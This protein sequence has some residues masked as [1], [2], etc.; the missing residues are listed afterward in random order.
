MCLHV[1]FFLYI[2]FFIIWILFWLIKFYQTNQ[3]MPL[4]VLKFQT[5][6]CLSGMYT[7]DVL[8]YDNSNSSWYKVT[9]TSSQI[10]G[11][12]F[13]DLS[14]KTNTICFIFFMSDPKLHS[15]KYM[16]PSHPTRPGILYSLQH[17]S[18]L[19]TYTTPWHLT[20]PGIL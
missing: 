4:K 7:V 9:L 14:S 13:L 16:T 6:S 5:W 10:L 18:S 12:M 8:S 2:D 1:F 17:L 15:L 20:R 3:A 19:L 11:K